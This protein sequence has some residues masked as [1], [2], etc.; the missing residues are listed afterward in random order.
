MVQGDITI[1]EDSTLTVEPGVSVI[2]EGYYTLNVQG[3]LLAIGSESE[4]ITFTINDTTGFFRSDTILG[5]WN[6]IQFIDTP[7]DNDT[8]KIIFC[9]FQ[10]AKA[11]GSGPEN[12]SG[13]AILIS[14]YDKVL[15]SD[16]LISN[17]SAGGLNSP[18]GGGLCLRSANIILKNNIISYNHAH[19]GGGIQIWESD[20]VFI[21]NQIIFNTADEGGGG[22]WIGG[23]SNSEFNGDIISDNIA[24]S[25]GGGINSW[26]TTNT[27]LNSVTFKN[28][29]ANWGGGFGAINCEV[30]MD[31]CTFND[32][33]SSTLCGGF[34][35]D[36]GTINI[37]N[38]SFEGD[39]ASVFG[40][41]IGVYFSEL[42]LKN[43]GLN[44]NSAGI[45]GGGIHSDSSIIEI[46]NTAFENDTSGDSG[47]A[48][49]IWL[50]NL[51]ID[52][53]DFNNNSAVYNGG[54]IS[55][56]SST[57]IIKNSD[58]SQNFATWGGGIINN[59]GK[60]QMDSC[61]FSENSSEHGGALSMNSSNAD[62]NN[63]S[64][65]QNSSNFGGGISSSNC[66]I[67]I[68][69]CLFYK[70]SVGN[71]AGGIE[72]TADTSG[73]ISMYQLEINNTIFKEN[74][75]LSRF[76]AM[77]VGQY[78]SN[79]PLVNVLIDKSE[80]LDNNAVRIGALRIENIYNFKLSNSR[81]IG[82]TVPQN[83][84]A[85]TFTSSSTGN[86]YNCLFANNF[87]GRGTSGGAG[88]SN[89][90]E[91][92][93][94][95]CTFV[96]N[97]SGGGGGIHVR[98][99]G[100]AVLTNSIL[101]GNHPDQI[102][103][104]AV[105]DTS[106]AVLYANYSDIQFGIDSIKKDDTIS[107]VNWGTGNIDSDPL[108]VDT[109][110]GDYHLKDLS[111]CIAGGIDS[112]E[113]SGLW[114]YSPLTDIERNVR[115]NPEG[116]NPDLGAYESPLPSAVGINNN[117]NKILTEFEIKQNY[118]NPFNP[119]TTIKYSIPDLETGHAPSLRYVTLKVYDILG[120]EIAVLVNEEQKPGYYEVKWDA[121]NQPS[122]VY[123]YRISAGDPS[124]NSGQD[125]VETKKMILM[126]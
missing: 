81:F 113:I 108:F 83:T 119:I 102:S 9:S 114:Y 45:L 115:P 125:Y 13:G 4:I 14:N 109:L 57:T 21:N 89:G 90:A 110:N 33:T 76:G 52:N 63:I 24:G 32:N 44:N 69:S 60:I 7:S 103:L 124:A 116:S 40:G 59:R 80:F 73:L 19:D 84:A 31:S 121:G 20:P 27:I 99:G 64:F 97:R 120:R 107:T 18:S 25:N 28:N 41:A 98:R 87:A 26:Q 54:A 23:I 100:A 49:F 15:I 93:F 68:D 85:C 111:P 43:S 55:S 11:V 96:N 74:S 77:T 48:I 112:I 117:M 53:C 67:K 35:S 75:S 12:N 86:V 58:F 3:R 8:S 62:I 88:I 118:P 51:L 6:G 78:Y 104:L 101:W 38:T 72:Y 47:G 126:K 46:S 22:I 36:Y 106:A 94:M 105:D 122:G 37:N 91:V 42:I 34:G 95:N 61:L 16:C 29:S 82:N 39:T 66:N 123:F 17:N 70:N 30:R 2:F 1:P 10:Y 71:Q 92:N 65:I 56:D 5:G 79:N 50:C